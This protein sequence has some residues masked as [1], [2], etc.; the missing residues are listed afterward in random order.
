M[1]L[2]LRPEDVLLIFRED[3]QFM[4]FLVDEL[5]YYNDFC[6]LQGELCFYPIDCPKYWSKEKVC[7][8]DNPHECSMLK[9]VDLRIFEG[10]D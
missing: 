7:S 9:E 8:D 3:Q 4:K 6:P 5:P 10:E 1:P 2:Y